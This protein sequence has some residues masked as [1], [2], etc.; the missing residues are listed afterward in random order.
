MPFALAAPSLGDAGGVA[1]LGFGGLGGGGM[2]AALVIVWSLGASAQ[3]FT[4]VSALAC[5]L[6]TS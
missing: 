3:V 6:L 2:F 4:L 1:G 5:V